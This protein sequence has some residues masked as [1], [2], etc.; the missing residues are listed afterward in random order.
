MSGEPT[1]LDLVRGVLARLAAERE[2]SG[3][4]SHETLVTLCRHLERL[5][6][7]EALRVGDAVR[8]VLAQ[9]PR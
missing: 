3:S 2:R 7:D 1:A 4:Y 9:R 5:S 6:P 8:R